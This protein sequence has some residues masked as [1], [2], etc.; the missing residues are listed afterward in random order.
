MSY[1]T[2]NPDLMM[3]TLAVLVKRAGGTVTI[4]ASETLGPFI[5]HS[6]FAPGALL[7]LVLQENVS[8][9]EAKRI[10]AED[11]LGTA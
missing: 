6:K 2:D 1:L 11:E 4:K 7:H 8:E 5:L 3:E 9:E 10:M